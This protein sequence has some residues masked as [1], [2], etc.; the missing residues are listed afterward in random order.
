VIPG[1][2]SVPCVPAEQIKDT[3]MDFD[4]LRGLKSGLGTAAVIVMDK[5]TDIIKAIA[6]LATSTS[7]RAAASARR[8]A[9][10][11]AGCGA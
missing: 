2:S 1:G 3:P 9:R 7:T 5:S 6:R 4:T 11:P 8:A 10:A